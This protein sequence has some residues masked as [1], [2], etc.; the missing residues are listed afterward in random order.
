MTC[1]CILDLGSY[2]YK[3]HDK[4]SFTFL[5]VFILHVLHDVFNECMA[6]GRA[7]SDLVKGQR[8]RD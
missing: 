4:H 3:N 8:G 1:I 6:F 5:R 7:C 2:C